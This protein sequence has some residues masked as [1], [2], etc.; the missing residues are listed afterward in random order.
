[1][2]ASSTKARD[3]PYATARLEALEYRFEHDTWTSFLERLES[4]NYCGAL[5]G[6]EGVGKTTL[7]LELKKK[8]SD[9]GFNP[10][11]LKLSGGKR[12]LPLSFWV[13][14][15]KTNRIILVD[16]AENLPWWQFQILKLKC[17]LHS[18]GLV[19]TAHK[20]GLLPTLIQCRTSLDL[21]DELSESLLGHKAETQSLSLVYQLSQGNIRLAFMHLYTDI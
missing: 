5:V 9:D 3:N 4:M 15:Q 14:S 7:L 17:K 11:L 10:L 8:L 1:M 20:E 21:L 16:S 18:L 6:P 2:V 12:S 13:D 19:V